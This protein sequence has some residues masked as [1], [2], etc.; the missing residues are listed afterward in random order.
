MLGMSILFSEM[1]P[2]RPWED[3]FNHW[4]DTEHIPLRMQVKG[5]ESAQ[6]Y[7]NAED[8]NYLA[9]YELASLAVFSTPEFQVIKAKPSETTAWMLANVKGFTRY[10]GDQMMGRGDQSGDALDAPVLLAV[11]LNVPQASIHDFDNWFEQDHMPNLLRNPDCR[12]IRHFTIVSGEPHQFNRL[13]LHYLA[14]ANVMT[15]Q[16]REMAESSL[17]RDDGAARWIEEGREMTFIKHG[18]RH[19]AHSGVAREATVDGDQRR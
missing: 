11:L 17:W 8:D 2:E 4:Y 6:R 19:I 10:L 18:A 13:A 15:S 1:R 12:M 5:F 3:R 7:R 16:R 9:V 14:S